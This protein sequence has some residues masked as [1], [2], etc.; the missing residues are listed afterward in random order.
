MDPRDYSG[1]SV[2]A[3]EDSGAAAIRTRIDSGTT[4]IGASVSVIASARGVGWREETAC[5]TGWER[6]EGRE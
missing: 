6:W 4:T 3:M 1:S 5:A 2:G